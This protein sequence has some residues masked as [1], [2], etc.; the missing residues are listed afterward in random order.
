MFILYVFDQ[1]KKK[2]S[3]S[4]VVVRQTSDR[5]VADLYGSILELAMRHCVPWKR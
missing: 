3:D 2:R 1:E 5:E 4:S